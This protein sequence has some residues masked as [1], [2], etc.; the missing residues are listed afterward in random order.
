MHNISEGSRLTQAC[1]ADFGTG[2][3]GEAAPQ[4]STEDG[5]EAKKRRRLGTISAR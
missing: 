3:G 1:N 5:E 2:E 4:P